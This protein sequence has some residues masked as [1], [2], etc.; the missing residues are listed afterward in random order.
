MLEKENATVI[1]GNEYENKIFIISSCNIDREMLK[2]LM[3]RYNI[4]GGGKGNY[5]M[6]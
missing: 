4:K 1:Y 5:F 3:E 6:I 2:E